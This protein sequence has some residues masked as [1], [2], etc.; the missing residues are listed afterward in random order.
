M[1]FKMIDLSYKIRAPR[2]K[3]KSSMINCITN[4]V[5]QKNTLQLSEIHRHAKFSYQAKHSESSEVIFQELRQEETKMK[6][7]LGMYGIL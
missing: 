6:S 4:I 1:G 7:F 3:K 5:H 2:A